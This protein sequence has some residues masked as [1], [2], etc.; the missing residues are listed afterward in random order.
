[1]AAPVPPR[2][3][4]RGSAAS[5]SRS[6]RFRGVG[7]DKMASP[8][9]LQRGSAGTLPRAG[10]RALRRGSAAG[11][12]TAS[13]RSTDPALRTRARAAKEVSRAGEPLLHNPRKPSRPGQSHLFLP[14]PLT[15]A[16]A[17]PETHARTYNPPFSRA[18]APAARFRA[19]AREGMQGARRWGQRGRGRGR[20]PCGLLIGSAADGHA[21]RRGGG[22]G[23]GTAQAH[24]GPVALAV[25]PAPDAHTP[26]L[27][28][29]ALL[30]AGILCSPSVSPV[31][32]LRMLA[33]R[34][35][36]VAT[37]PCVCV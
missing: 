2:G 14:C 19:R 28:R 3:G 24:Y 30:I 12:D 18:L 32:E 21:P 23:L 37:R 17:L 31:V 29:G 8:P 5:P 13:A 35:A 6:A 1:M 7:R 25:P 22:G 36:W 20:A 27:F 11:W 33:Q 9:P 16:C 10:E 15:P 34:R 26:C 4:A